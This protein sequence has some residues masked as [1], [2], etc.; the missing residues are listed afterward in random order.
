MQLGKGKK[1]EIFEF[2]PQRAQVSLLGRSL[3]EQIHA[4]N[5]NMKIG[6]LAPAIHKELKDPNTSRY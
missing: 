2:A 3:N 5:S 4:D 1:E 6:T